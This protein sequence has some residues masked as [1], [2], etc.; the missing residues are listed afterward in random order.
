MRKKESVCRN[1]IDWNDVT[2]STIQNAIRKYLNTKYNCATGS[3]FNLLVRQAV[4]M[5]WQVGA[6]K[7]FDDDEEEINFKKRFAIS[8]SEATS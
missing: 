3:R 1:N 8:K 6:I 4:E 7:H 5:E 2:F